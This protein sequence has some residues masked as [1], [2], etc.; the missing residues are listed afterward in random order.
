MT[1]SPVVLI[2]TIT[3]NARAHAHAHAHTLSLDA[4]RRLRAGLR[5][6][7]SDDVSA[8]S[9][10][11]YF[12]RRARDAMCD[13]HMKHKQAIALQT[14]RNAVEV[15]EYIYLFLFFYFTIK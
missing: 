11:K 9:R 2:I 5:C 8:Q 1:T 4:E 12:V 14:Q 13:A 7:T 10:P 15:L 3:A 6:H